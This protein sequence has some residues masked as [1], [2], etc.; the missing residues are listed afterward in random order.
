MLLGPGWEQSGRIFTFFGPG[1]GIM[2]LYGTHGWIH[3][4]IGRADR[5]FRWGIVELVVTVMLF[6]LGLRWG[7]P[8]IAVA[9]T[10]SF[11][12]LTI[13]ALWYAG[14]PI[15][16]GV[17]P[18]LKVIW[19]YVVASVLAAVALGLIMRR[20]PLFGAGATSAVLLGRIVIVS[21][22]YGIL[23][24]AV[25]ILLHGSY[26]PLRPVVGLFVEM[27]PF[28]KVSTPLTNSGAGRTVSVLN[29]TSSAE[30]L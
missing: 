4:S 9:W 6:I 17:G 14:R 30:T 13:P 26:K 21:L 12:I 11:W 5:W 8:G 28:G 1:I 10:A 7:P 25:V 15:D 24:V 16:F 23:Y 20:L 18:V 27:I 29:P 3:L 22:L 19:K 2:F